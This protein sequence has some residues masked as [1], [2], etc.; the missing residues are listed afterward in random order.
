MNFFSPPNLTSRSFEFVQ[1]TSKSSIISKHCFIG[2]AITWLNIIQTLSSA[3]PVI[4]VMNKLDSR[5]KEIDEK[6][7]KEK[8]PDIKGFFKVSAIDGTNISMLAKKIEDEVSK[9][10]RMSTYGQLLGIH[11]P[12]CL[13][14]K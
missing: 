5:V 8:F 2:S 9:L 1:N 6:S 11:G 4:V 12:F 3:S 7:L 13:S 14:H 10:G